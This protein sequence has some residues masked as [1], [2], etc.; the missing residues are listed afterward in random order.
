MHYWKQKVI[1]LTT[2][3]APLAPYVVF[4]RINL[5]GTTSDDNVVK[6]AIFRFQW[7]A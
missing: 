1:N 2:L 4:M 7:R 5:N 3:S 6:W